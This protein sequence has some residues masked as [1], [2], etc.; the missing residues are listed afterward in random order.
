M[1]M[2]K[3]SLKNNV[4]ALKSGLADLVQD[5][6]AGGI[7][8]FELRSKQDEMLAAVYDN[9][10]S[11][12]E[13]SNFYFTIPTGVGKTVLF[14]IMARAFQNKAPDKQVV[15]FVPRLALVGQTRQR[16][17]EQMKYIDDEIGEWHKSSKDIIGK[18]VIISTYQSLKKLSDSLDH[19][20][21]GLV[22][23]DEAHHALTEARQGNLDM[24]RNTGAILAGF[25]AT[26]E[27]SADKKVGNFLETEIY[28]LPIKEAVENKLVSQIQC[29]LLVSRVA[30]N[31]QD[32]NETDIIDTIKNAKLEE[33]SDT[34]T[35]GVRDGL[36]IFQEEIANVCLGRKNADFALRK[37]IISC[38]DTATA[39]AQAEV[40]NR[41][42]GEEIAV[43][44]HSNKK[45]SGALKDDFVTGK[46]RIAVQVN[47]LTEGF[48]DEDVSLVINYPTKSKT[49]VEQSSGRGTRWNPK[50]PNKICHVIDTIF[51]AELDK[52]GNA[53]KKEV[54]KSM[55]CQALYARYLNNIKC[56]R[57][58]ATFS[59]TN[60]KIK[61]AKESIDDAHLNHDTQNFTS[62]DLVVDFVEMTELLN[63]TKELDEKYTR[64]SDE[65][66]ERILELLDGGKNPKSI[67]IKIGRAHKT[68]LDHLKRI[69]RYENSYNSSLSDWEKTEIIR[70]N[71][72]GKNHAEI[73]MAIGRNRGT[74]GAYL[75]SKGVFD[76]RGL[77]DL[78]KEKIIELNNLGNSD[79]QIASTLKRSCIAV[80]DYLESQG[81]KNSFQLSKSEKTE[82]TRLSNL[83]KNRSQ[84]AAAIGRSKNT[85]GNHLKCQMNG[86]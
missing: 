25:T 68:I 76:P 54:V 28:N 8:G 9:D 81:R 85:V 5:I 38:P 46:Y 84:I 7:P 65:E 40:I 33:T 36:E 79:R 64:L 10:R 73:G 50:D 49:K 71:N 32:V 37:T 41:L 82:I 77:S 83:G 59:V 48:D 45:N 56:L 80:T 6:K 22:V 67:A 75:R 72:L 30:T 44:V 51:C 34:G 86:R 18:K 63:E 12:E 43:S 42:A 3:I 55:R 66:K 4:L 23:A 69:G 16:L 78:E 24:F 47:Q 52:D 14:S 57:K 20:K 15:I 39:D 26:P 58:A 60:E 62:R 19:S 35:V 29:S 13:M 27:Y 21:I 53:S 61:E 11:A 1:E 74:V 17:T 2:Q 31:L 70:L